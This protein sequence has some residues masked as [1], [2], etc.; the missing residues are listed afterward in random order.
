MYILHWGTVS[1]RLLGLE[2]TIIIGGKEAHLPWTRSWRGPFERME[3][4]NLKGRAYSKHE[5]PFG[6]TEMELG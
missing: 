2:N 4:A 6:K 1:K 5:I 3:V